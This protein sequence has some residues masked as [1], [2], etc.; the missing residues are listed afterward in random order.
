MKHSDSIVEIT[1][2]LSK[3]QGEIK[4][5]LCNKTNPYFD[6]KYADLGTILD[7]AR[8][9]L[10]RNGLAMIQTPSTKLEEKTVRISGMLVH[11]SGEYFSDELDLPGEAKGKDGIM[12]FNAQTIGIAITYGRRYQIS[13]FL[14]IAS[15]EDTDGNGLGG[16]EGRGDSKKTTPPKPT[17]PKPTKKQ[18][19]E[20]PKHKHTNEELYR[21]CQDGEVALREEG[22]VDI[23]T[24][25][26]DMKELENVKDDYEMMYTFYKATVQ[27]YNEGKKK[28]V[29]SPAESKVETEQKEIY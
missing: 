18:K 19:P 2:A 15:E 20:K 5:A 6:S 26:K 13:P 27:Q 10:S 14:G 22:I 25:T 7:I 4:N 16:A 29:E 1:K 23:D 8:P 3:A 12:K 28:K 9:I 24:F 11:T 17:P 21:K